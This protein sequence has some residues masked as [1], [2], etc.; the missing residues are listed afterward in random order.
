VHHSPLVVK[1]PGMRSQLPTVVCLLGALALAAGCGE[2][3][4]GSVEEG[5]ESTSTTGT[6]GTTTTPA[7]RGA[8]VAKVVVKETDFALDPKNPRIAKAGVVTF[9]VSNAG[10][11]LHALEVEGPGGEVKTKGIDPGG[12]ATLKVDLSK[13]GTYEWYCPIDD[14]KGRGMKGRIIVAGG[15]PDAGTS[16]DG[17]GTK[18]D[19]TGK[20]GDGPGMSGCSG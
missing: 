18:T 9:D 20:G 5:G 2:D 7:P 3:R 13:P 19:D 17:S 1:V 15:G 10:K 8:A 4:G 11:L 14:H 16:T 12:K 6:T